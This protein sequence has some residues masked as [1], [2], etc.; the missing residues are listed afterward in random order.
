[1]GFLVVRVAGVVLGVLEEVLRG[2]AHDVYVV[3][4]PGGEVLLPAV[5]EVVREVRVED[6]QITV[7]PVPGLLEE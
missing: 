7:R 4:G 3:R 2:P 6:R 5:R 1:L